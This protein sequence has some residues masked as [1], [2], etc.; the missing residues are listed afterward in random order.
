[1]NK[2]GLSESTISQIIN[3]FKQ[4]PTVDKVIIYGSRA[5]GNYKPGSD[6]DLTILGDRIKEQDFTKIFTDLDDLYIPYTFDLSLYQQ[7]DS[8]ALKSHISRIGQV[9]YER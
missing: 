5:K 1:M 2:Y 7:I 4:Y 8:D 9:F 3:V 6:I